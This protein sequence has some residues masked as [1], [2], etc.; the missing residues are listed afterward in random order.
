MT[1]YKPI[2]KFTYARRVKKLTPGRTST[3]RFKGRK[4]E[5]FLDPDGRQL[6]VIK[7]PKQVVPDLLNAET[8]RVVDGTLQAVYRKPAAPPKPPKKVEEQPKEV[9]AEPRVEP[10]KPVEPAEAEPQPEPKPK[11]APKPES[12][13]A[14]EPEPQP[15]PLKMVKPKALTEAERRKAI[16]VPVPDK[17]PIPTPY[18]DWGS[19]PEH[20]KVSGIVYHDYPI[21]GAPKGMLPE[22]REMF[23]R[24]RI[25]QN[26]APVNILI[27][28][29]KGTGKSELIKRFAEDA[30]LPYWSVIGQEGIR[31]DE[32]LGHYELEK[33]TSRWADGLIPRAVRAGG[34]LHIDEANVLEPAILMRLDELLDNK[35]QL[36]MEDLNGE[37]VKA[38]PDLFVIFTMNPPTYEGVKALPEPIV[39]RLG[40]RYFMNYPPRHIEL[41]ILEAKLRRMGVKP[42]EFTAPTGATAEMKPA[43]GMMANDVEDLLKVVRGLRTDTE[44]SY[45]PSMRETIGFVQDLR[46]GDGFHKAF[47]TNI[48][49]YYYGDEE[50]KVEEALGSV[51][52]R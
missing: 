16:L 30:G 31:A 15:K 18:I 1:K 29:W 13:P 24:S 27:Q 45:T 8:V 41:Q 34:I 10:E 6:S 23:R 32:L 48:K 19:V 22:L 40:K 50:T 38:H 17:G 35:R 36:N 25:H 5:V 21:P 2:A 46:Q 43:T 20:S 3:L 44:I 52:R 47:D 39:S 28:G 14:P 26:T 11:P 7:A 49:S 12:K 42:A 33:G 9:V 51:R 37:V 4:V